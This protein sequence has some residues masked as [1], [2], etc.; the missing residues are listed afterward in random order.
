MTEVGG[1]GF[2]ITIGQFS[3]NRRYILEQYSSP[4]FRENLLDS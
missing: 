2:M 1:D 3:L 4:Y